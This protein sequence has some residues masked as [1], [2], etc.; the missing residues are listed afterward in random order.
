MRINKFVEILKN[1]FTALL[2]TFIIGAV[3]K[4]FWNVFK[5]GWDL[6]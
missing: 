1:A 2:G 4:I 6:F 5:L 3:A